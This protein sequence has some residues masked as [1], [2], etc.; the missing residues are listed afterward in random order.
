MGHLHSLSEIWKNDIF[1]V[2]K[3]FRGT[4]KQWKHWDMVS[5]ECWNLYFGSNALTLI[6]IEVQATVQYKKC[7]LFMEKMAAWY[8][9]IQTPHFQKSPQ[10]SKLAFA[11]SS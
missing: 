10:F 3:S 4:E 1:V 11:F 2:I 5:G 7:F 8:E 9:G 6:F